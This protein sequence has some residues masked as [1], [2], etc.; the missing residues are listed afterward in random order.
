[1]SLS[2]S[3]KLFVLTCHSRGPACSS[4]QLGQGSSGSVSLACHTPTG[5]L[6]AVKVGEATCCAVGERAQLLMRQLVGPLQRMSL[7]VGTDARQILAELDALRD[8]SECANIVGFYGAFL[9]GNILNVVLEYMDIGSLDRCAATG[10][11]G[12]VRVPRAY[13]HGV[14][15]VQFARPVPEI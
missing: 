11:D 4:R 7:L 13:A 2:V 14:L 3:L 12:V 1:M 15:H 9:S 8:C 10:S 5:A 6:V